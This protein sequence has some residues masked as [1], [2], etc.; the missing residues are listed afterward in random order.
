MNFSFF[1]LSGIITEV[2]GEGKDPLLSNGGNATDIALAPI[3][4]KNLD[5]WELPRDKL[6]ELVTLG[7]GK[8]GRVYKAEV[9]LEGT[10]KPTLATVKEFEAIEEKEHAAEFNTEVEML[11][12]L[13]HENVAR[14]L[15]VSTSKEGSGGL[16]WLL[17]TEFCKEVCLDILKLTL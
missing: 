14:L 3:N 17:I 1:D 15:G 5:R 6:S 11:A 9:V 2:D 10:E 12:Q 16:P 7:H 8:M 4:K 13:D